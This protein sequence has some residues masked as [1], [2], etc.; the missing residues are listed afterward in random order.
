M[1]HFYGDGHGPAGA[2]AGLRSPGAADRKPGDE[3]SRDK[4]GILINRTDRPGKRKAA[5]SGA[6]DALPSTWALLLGPRCYTLTLL[7]VNHLLSNSGSF[8]Q[9]LACI[10]SFYHTIFAGA[11]TLLA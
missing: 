10:I 7:T 5:Q 9:G 6:A 11:G 1:D 2:M 4:L 3:D 8:G